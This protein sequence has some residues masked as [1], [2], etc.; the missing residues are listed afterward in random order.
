MEYRFDQFA[1]HLTVYYMAAR[2]KLPLDDSLYSLDVDELAFFH[3]QT[4]IKDDAK[5]KEHIIAVQEK[6]YEVRTAL[7]L[8]HISISLVTYDRV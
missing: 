7:V 2:A 8:R 4:G 1:F 3:E 6:A 5:L